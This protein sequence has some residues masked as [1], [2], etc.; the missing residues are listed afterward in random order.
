MAESESVD[1]SHAACFTKPRPKNTL[2]Q[3]RIVLTPRL[4]FERPPRPVA[5]RTPAPNV[6]ARITHTPFFSTTESQL[7]SFFRLPYDI[8]L[9][10]YRYLVSGV[11]VQY[12]VCVATSRLVQY[13]QHCRSMRDGY[14]YARH[15][16]YPAILECSRLCHE[17][18]IPV[19][20]RENIF[21]TAWCSGRSNSHC[22]EVVNSWSLPRRHL[23][24][25]SN[26]EMAIWR[27]A[28][29]S[30]DGITLSRQPDLF[31]ALKRLTLKVRLSALQWGELL[32]FSAEI[33][34][35]LH[36]IRFRLDV[37]TEEAEAIWHGNELDKEVVD[38]QW[39]TRNADVLCYRL[40]EPALR[41]H[42]WLGKT[43]VN[44]T[45]YDL[46]DSYGLGW[47][48]GLDLS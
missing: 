34:R 41:K 43:N 14:P 3:T 31:P 6:I 26:L 5:S 45:F 21:Q 23:K 17:E 15:E 29:L 44:W 13:R 28:A 33:L 4:G 32:D 48:V 12:S 25:I 19:L 22:W 42:G 18:G 24:Y 7:T 39:E 38:G 46:S 40:Y 10:L 20:Y 37:S 36:T 30:E 2:R 16:L 1:A 8:R 35:S 11:H 27:D 9:Q 47:D